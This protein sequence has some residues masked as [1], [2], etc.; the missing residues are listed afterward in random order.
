MDAGPPLDNRE[1][2]PSL[3]WSPKA[4][5]IE[6]GSRTLARTGKV[7]SNVLELPGPARVVFPVRLAPAAHRDLIEPRLGDSEPSSVGNI[8]QLEHPQGH[9]LGRIHVRISS[10]LP[11]PG[12]EPFRLHL[13]D[14]D[15]ERKMLV[16]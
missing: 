7:S 5:N 11:A 4:A 12:K 15:L 10:R 14:N 1:T 13:L 3:V 9:R 2:R 16:F 8:L 6:A